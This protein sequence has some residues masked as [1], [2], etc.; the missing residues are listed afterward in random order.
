MLDESVYRERIS[1]VQ[2]YL[3]SAGATFAFLTPSPNFQ[4]LAGFKY[5]MRERLIALIIKK[6]EKPHIIV[7]AFELTD[8]ASH[9]WIDDLLPWAEDENPYSVVA[10]LVGVKSGGHSVLVDA[11][12]PLGIFWALEE[13]LGS[14]HEASSIS[15]L[16]ESMRVIKS[17]SEIELM[18]QAGRIISDAVF[19]AFQE[20]EIGVTELEVQTTVHKE[21]RRQGATP[22]FAAVQFGENSAI[23]HSASGNRVLRK[24]DVV[25]MDCGCEIDGYNTDMTRVGVAGTPTEEIKTVYSTVL[26]AQETA[27]G[28]VVAGMTCGTADG[29]ARRI[30]DDAGF[31]DYFTHRLGHGIGIEVHEQPYVVR[32][33]SQELKSGMCH[34]IEPG[35]YLEGKFGIRIEDLVCIRDG[36]PELLTFMSRDLI[37]IGLQ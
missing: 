26:R 23:P 14:F 28:K 31:G 7:P 17:A 20:A 24:G 5:D 25:L 1:R 8:H 11:N 30:I 10:N 2:N 21:I 35:I 15:P 27:I 12:T 29:I 13:A 9:T 36:K 6:D 32:G 33:N 37:Q 18:K 22:T 16:I 19:K 34:S 3:D 4:Y